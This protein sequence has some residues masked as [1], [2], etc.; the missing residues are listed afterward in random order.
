MSPP[1]QRRARADET[2]RALDNSL[3]SAPIVNHVGD[4][5]ALRYGLSAFYVRDHDAQSIA[6]R[7]MQRG[8]KLNAVQAEAYRQWLDEQRQDDAS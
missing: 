4:V 2:T 5:V 8:R 7:R 6:R 3:A 1:G